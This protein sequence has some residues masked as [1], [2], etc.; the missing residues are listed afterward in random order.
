M[1]KV[2]FQPSSNEE[3]KEEE[4]QRKVMNVSNSDDLYEVF[5]RPL[6]PKT[7]TGDLGQFSQPLPSHFEEVASLEDKMGIQRKPRSTLQ[8]HL[9]SQPEREAPTKVPQTR[10]PTPHPPTQPLRTDPTDPKRKRDDKGKEVMEGGK[11]LPPLETKHQMAANQPRTVQTR[12]ATEGDKRV[13]H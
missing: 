1:P 6:S 8:E 10:L 3:S 11:N 12:L 7:L 9:E 2:D 13:D 4:R 5:D